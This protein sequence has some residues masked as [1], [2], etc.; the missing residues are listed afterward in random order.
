MAIL[1]NGRYTFGNKS[2]SDIQAIL[3]QTIALTGLFTIVSGSNS[4]SGS[5]TLFTTELTV[6]NAISF[7]ASGES[8]IVQSITNN[9]S[10]TLT[11]NVITSCAGGVTCTAIRL[12]AR[13]IKP[14]DTVFNTTDNFAMVYSGD[15][16][17]FTIQKWSRGS[18]ANGQV[19]PI[20]NGNDVTA[21]TEGNVLTTSSSESGAIIAY[22]TGTQQEACAI[23][24]MTTS[25]EYCLPSA[26]CGIHTVNVVS[27]GGSPTST[28]PWSKGNFLKP[29]TSVTTGALTNASNAGAILNCGVLTTTVASASTTP[30]Q[31]KTL[32][33]FIQRF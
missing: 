16:Q 10:L 33:N 24:Y 4:V 7:N 20:K 8:Y 28:G 21:I 31:I 32:V 6:G 2:K 29:S 27:N 17:G 18:F 30:I 23:N 25:G 11:K 13:G 22:L 14:G 19:V 5:G 15:G 3:N 9:T 1:T 26:V 12:N